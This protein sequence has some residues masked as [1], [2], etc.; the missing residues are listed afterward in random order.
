VSGEARAD[1]IVREVA[2]AVGLAEGEAGVRDVIAVVRRLGVAPTRVI[3][4]ATGLPVPIVAAIS[5]ELRKR[6]VVARDRPTRLTAFGSGLFGGSQPPLDCACRACAGRGL[7]VPQGLEPL[8]AELAALAETAPP[9][10]SELDQSHCT[11]ETKLRRALAL[12]EAGA[13]EGKRVLL[14][15]DDDLTSLAVLRLTARCG[16][17]GSIHELVVV[18]VDPAVL[19]YIGGWLQEAPFPVWRIEHDLCL[20]LPAS[21]TGRFDTVFTDPPYTPAGAELFLSRAAAAL[22]PVPGGRVFLSFGPKPPEESLRLQAAI[23]R[24][25]FVIRRITRNFNDYVQAGIIGGTSHLYELTSTGETRPLVGGT[26]EGALYTGEGRPA[27]PYRCVSCG[28]VQRVGRGSR[29][30]T[31]DLLRTDGCP[32]CGA[33]RFRPLPR[34]GARRATPSPADLRL[35]RRDRT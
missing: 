4:R 15:G 33:A 11:P 10:R 13:L 32:E 8:A 30:T 31:V 26:Y 20:P 27:R 18:D 1:A 2:V 28:S 9:A 34:R 17:A 16:V 29:W 6:E 12:Y 25:G 35:P 3:S 19:D 24:M 14:L 5:G 7:I 22:A 21:L 23:A